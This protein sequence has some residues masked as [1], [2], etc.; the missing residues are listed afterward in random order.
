[1][2]NRDQRFPVVQRTAKAMAASDPAQLRSGRE[3]ALSESHGV[4]RL[5]FHLAKYG[6][7]DLQLRHRPS[8]TARFAAERRTIRA[9]SDEIARPYLSF[10]LDMERKV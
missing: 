4:E 9:S 6:P 2:S 10:A 7:L 5:P 8:R 3:V 1:M